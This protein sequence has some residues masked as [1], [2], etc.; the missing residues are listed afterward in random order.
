VGIED[1]YQRALTD[2][3]AD[4]DALPPALW[5]LLREQQIDMTHDDELVASTTRK[6]KRSNGYASH[7][8]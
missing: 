7:L 2:F 5:V 1:V 8:G 3:D 6:P 4:P